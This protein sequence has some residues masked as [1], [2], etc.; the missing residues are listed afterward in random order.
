MSQCPN[1]ANIHTK[2]A[3][4]TDPNN[5]KSASDDPPRRSEI[6]TYEA[7]WHVYA[8]NWSV[9]RDK[10]YRLAISSLVEHFHNQVQIVHLDEPTGEILPD[11]GVALTHPYPPT[12]TIFVPDPECQKPDRSS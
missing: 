3:A 6:Y 4:I 9:R 12:K 8:I 10:P 7:P 5:S 11:P 2:M 1:I